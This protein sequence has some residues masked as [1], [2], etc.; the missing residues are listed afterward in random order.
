MV[1][2]ILLIS[3]FLVLIS[4]CASEPSLTLTIPQEGF[5]I[6]QQ[7]PTPQQEHAQ[8]TLYQAARP[9]RQREFGTPALYTLVDSLYGTMLREEG[10]GIAANQVGKRLQL[11]IIEAKASNGRYQVLGAVPK[12][13]F[14]NPRVT[15]VSKSHSNFW[16]GC[17]SAKGKKRGNVATYSWVEYESYSLKGKLE[18]GRLEGFAAVIFQHEFRHLLGGTYLDHTRHLV[19]KKELD[20][21]INQG[22]LPF[23]ETAPDSLPHLLKDY[24]IGESL[25]DY[26]KRENKTN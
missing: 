4:A 5:E 9:I 1:K 26:Y 17:L 21:L 3:I 22:A 12:Q 14:L 23:F 18:K 19:A 24:Q 2:N 7:L 10:V 8:N 6:I 11:F 20:S 25:E 13:V 15:K 16:H